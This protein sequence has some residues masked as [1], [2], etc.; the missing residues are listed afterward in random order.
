MDDAGRVVIP[1]DLR[2]RLGWRAGQ[3]FGDVEVG[4][5]IVLQPPTVPMRAERRGATLVAVTEE[6]MP[7]LTADAVRDVVERTRR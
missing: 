5:Q 3:E 6:A 1:K 2:A 7:V 4:G